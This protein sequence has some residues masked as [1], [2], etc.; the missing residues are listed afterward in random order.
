MEAGIP[1]SARRAVGRENLTVCSW[2][3][4]I[5]PWTANLGRRRKAGAGTKASFVI[6]RGNGKFR[7]KWT[8]AVPQ[9]SSSEWA[10]LAER[11]MSGSPP[12]H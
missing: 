6:M 8:F 1:R 11:R 10:T 12:N 3:S 5:A 7:L 4:K 9:Q 2:G